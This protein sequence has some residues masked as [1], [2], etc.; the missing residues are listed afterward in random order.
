MDRFSWCLCSPLW[1]EVTGLDSILSLP[2]TS[3]FLLP[4]CWI[5]SSNTNLLSW[6][7]GSV[8]WVSG[9][10]LMSS[11]AEAS[12]SWS[13]CLWLALLVDP[14]HEPFPFVEVLPFYGMDLFLINP[15]T[16]WTCLLRYLS[17]VPVTICLVNLFQ[18]VLVLCPW[19]ALGSGRWLL[20]L[21]MGTASSSFSKLPI[22]L[23]LG[24]FRPKF[25]ILARVWFLHVALVLSLPIIL[26][27]CSQPAGT[28]LRMLSV[29][30]SGFITNWHTDF[31]ILITT[32]KWLKHPVCKLALLYT[33]SSTS[34]LLTFFISDL[35]AFWSQKGNIYLMIML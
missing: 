18:L 31:Q 14:H 7:P 35:F 21:P 8:S 17:L 30:D 34:L 9:M 26:A 19:D 4:S 33:S 29:P 1:V 22:E 16:R 13:P 11:G 5:S 6:I 28:K 23:P 12:Q 24:N 2:A 15:S 32:D 27:S 20:S 3:S 10:P 25:H